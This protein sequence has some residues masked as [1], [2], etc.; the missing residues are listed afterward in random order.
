LRRNCRKIVWKDEGEEK[1]KIRWKST[2]RKRRRKQ[3]RRRGREGGEKKERI[4]E[5]S[6]IK[7]EYK[8]S[9]C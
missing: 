5:R 4:N 1:E 9:S 8:S 6:E 2:A 3:R 7:D